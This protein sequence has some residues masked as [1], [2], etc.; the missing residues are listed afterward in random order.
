MQ[1]LAV[2]GNLSSLIE[3][4]SSAKIRGPVKILVS[5]SQP[6]E[7]DKK[8]IDNSVPATKTGHFFFKNY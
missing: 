7:I 4:L 2:V 3:I 6:K 8:R 1:L 5:F